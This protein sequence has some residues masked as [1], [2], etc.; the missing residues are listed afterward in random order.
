FKIYVIDSWSSTWVGDDGDELS[1]RRWVHTAMVWNGTDVEFY[2]DGAFSYSA[3]L[4]QANFPDNSPATVYIGATS[5]A[6]ENYNGTI[7]D[8]MIFNRSLSATEISALYANTSTKYVSNN[9]TG[10]TTGAHTFKA[11]AQDTA[12][13]VNATEQR[14]VTI[15]SDM[16]TPQITI[17][18][19]ANTTYASSSINFNVSSNENLSFC[20]VTINNWVTNYT[21]T[22]NSSLRGANYTNS[23]IA[24]GS[25]TAKF[26]CNDTS[27]N[28]NNSEQVTFIANIIPTVS[29]TS[30]ANGNVTTNRTPEFTWTGS[31][32]GGGPSALTYEINITCWEAGSIVTAGSVYVNKATLGSV[33]SYIPTSYLK[34][35]SD[36]NQLYNWTVR[37]YDGVNYSSWAA[38][39]NL[40][41]QSLLTISL[42]VSSVNFG[43]M[44]ISDTENT[45][46]NSPPPL[47]LS[48]DGNA[49]L[50]ISANFTD[51]WDSIANPSNNF[52][53]KVRNL[54]S[55]CF[56]T[57]G[58]QT[59]WANSP[60]ITAKVIN[61]LNFT[62]GYQTGC[63]NTSVDLLVTVP[64]DES[65]GD[66]S[67]I[68]TFISSLGE[69]K[70]T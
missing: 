15:Q 24:D 62:S 65:P 60:S 8:V 31:D 18:S 37:A 7:D 66:K 35:L 26:W 28:I 30:P 14:S 1:S 9:F 6:N 51:L 5:G 70:Q 12:G 16:T 61:R 32:T 38:E 45:S 46:D 36:N 49:E 13:N 53:F 52:Q 48:N 23:S 4:V 67:S 63:S 55:G 68:I 41:I 54:S 20:K 34:C 57:S 43:N 22:L 25:Y 42:P 21:M 29:L 39:R 40:S 47:V 3:V 17:I 64:D 27:N 19:P 69:P 10:L 50:N 2:T 11:Y 33:T 59:S 44:N 58:S 56:V